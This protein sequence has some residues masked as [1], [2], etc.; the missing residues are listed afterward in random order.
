MFD[1]LDTLDLEMP[2]AADSGITS[3]DDRRLQDR[4]AGWTWAAMSATRASDITLGSD[5]LQAGRLGPVVWQR[6]TTGVG[7]RL[8]AWSST[9]PRPAARPSI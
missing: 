5:A 4:H 3:G 8:G 6:R 7:R 9:M 2:S 1:D